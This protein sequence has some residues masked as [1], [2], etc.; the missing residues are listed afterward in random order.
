MQLSTLS[1]LNVRKSIIE[2][3]HVSFKELGNLSFKS[4]SNCASKHVP[5]LEWYNHPFSKKA[6]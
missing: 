5:S 3:R 1:P 6:N 4:V 2:D